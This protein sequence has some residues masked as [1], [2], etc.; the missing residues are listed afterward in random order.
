MKSRLRI[1]PSFF[2]RSPFLLSCTF[3]WISFQLQYIPSWRK[4]GAHQVAS[5]LLDR[6]MATMARMFLQ[7]LGEESQS[8]KYLSGMLWREQYATG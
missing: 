2:I 1:S 8:Q 7:I 5:E 4:D 6:T 3:V